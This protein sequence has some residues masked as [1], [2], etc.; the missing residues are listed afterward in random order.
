MAV[1]QGQRRMGA[2]RKRKELE[3]QVSASK[4][5][6]GFGLPPPGDV[7]KGPALVGVSGK[8]RFKKSFDQPT[9]GR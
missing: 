5:M 3:A 9:V 6:R 2:P 8:W 7:S 1:R 4:G